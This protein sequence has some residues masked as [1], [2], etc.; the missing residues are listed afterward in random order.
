MAET[1]AFLAGCSMAQ[2]DYQRSNFNLAVTRPEGEPIVLVSL[3]VTNGKGRIGYVIASQN[4]AMLGLPLSHRPATTRIL[5]FSNTRT[6]AVWRCSRSFI[7]RV[8][9]VAGLSCG[10]LLIGEVL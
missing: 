9:F 10:Y 4:P 6:E 7:A 3:R 5:I 8:R 2:H 1:E